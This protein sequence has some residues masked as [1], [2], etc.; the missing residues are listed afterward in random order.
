M[1]RVGDV[2]LKPAH[3]PIRIAKKPNTMSACTEATPQVPDSFPFFS[4]VSKASTKER[5]MNERVKN[6]HPTVKPV[7]IMYQML[8]RRT[9]ETIEGPFF[10][11][12]S[13]AF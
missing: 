12:P 7:Q 9:P 4:Y 1:G 8:S 13:C 3:E 5:T 6:T 10:N 2:S 11:G